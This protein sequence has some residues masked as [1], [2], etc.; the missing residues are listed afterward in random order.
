MPE[1]PEVES[2]ARYLQERIVGC[3]IEGVEV[4]WERSVTT[5]SAK[6]FARILSGRQIAQ[7]RRRGKFICVQFT[8]GPEMLFAHMRMSGSFDVVSADAA[9]DQHDRIIFN[10]SGGKQLRF[11]DPRKFGRF[12]LVAKA[13]QVVGAL[14]VEPLAPQFTVAK[15]AELLRGQAARIKPFLLRQDR[16]AGLG[17]IYVDEVLW[18]ARVH[19]LRPAGALKESEIALLHQGIRSIL[20]EAIQKSGTDFGDGVVYGGGYSPTMYGRE[21]EPCLRCGREIQRLVVGQRGTHI[22]PGCQRA[23]RRRT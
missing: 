17:N 13:E 11:C 3:V 21:G 4:R 19:P 8:P 7:V 9:D 12:Y 18:Y 15:L 1:L 23:P 22:C 14:G 10:L 16:I 6:E 2:T 5:H 20:H